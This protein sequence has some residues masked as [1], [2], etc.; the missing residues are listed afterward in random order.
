[1]DG[2]D[3]LAQYFFHVHFC[4]YAFEK[5][6]HLPPLVRAESKLQYPFEL[7]CHG[8]KPEIVVRFQQETEQSDFRGGDTDV[9]P[10]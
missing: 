3:L 8:E 7:I 9:H 6:H 2:G 4:F 5:F 10:L 1:M